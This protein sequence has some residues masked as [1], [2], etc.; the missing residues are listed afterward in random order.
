MSRCKSCGA[1]IKW[2]TMR[3]GKAMPVDTKKVVYWKKE[4]A[5]G[6][7]ITPDGDVVSCMFSGDPSEATGV[8]YISHFSTCPNAGAHRRRK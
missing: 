7:V 2:I 8:G 1:T 6:K 4:G 5:A 3:S